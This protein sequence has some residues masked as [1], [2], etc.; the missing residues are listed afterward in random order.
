VAKPPRAL[1]LFSSKVLSSRI[2]AQIT[3]PGAP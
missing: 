1:A 2:L 3:Q